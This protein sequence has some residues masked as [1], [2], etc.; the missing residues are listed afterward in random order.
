MLPAWWLKQATCIHDHES[1]DWHKTTDWLGRPSPD[2]G[3]MQIDVRTW[4]SMAPR[5][6]PVDPAASTPRQQLIVAYRIYVANGRRFGGNQWPNSS[7]ECG[8]K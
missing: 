7:R 6:F 4:T 5:G 3:G 8:L 1:V 2:Q